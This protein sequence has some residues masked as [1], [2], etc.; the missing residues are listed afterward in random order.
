LLRSPRFW[1]PFSAVRDPAF[2]AQLIDICNARP[3]PFEYF[4]TSNGRF[5][6]KAKQ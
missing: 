1:L 5:A 4:D 6:L 2:L 3:A